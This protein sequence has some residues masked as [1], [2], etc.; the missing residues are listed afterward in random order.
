MRQEGR[1]KA[2]AQAQAKAEAAGCDDYD[3]DGDGDTGNSKGNVS[4]ILYSKKGK[5]ILFEL[6]KNNTI[7]L[8][9][10]HVL[11]RESESVLI[12]HAEV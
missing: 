10:K 1:G 7:K 11:R 8:A 3:G 12:N 2:E 4:P 6:E 5:N 9:L